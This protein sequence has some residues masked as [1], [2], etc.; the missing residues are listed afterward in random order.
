MPTK[1]PLE[2]ESDHSDNE[3]SDIEKNTTEQLSIDDI[4]ES[5]IDKTEKNIKKEKNIM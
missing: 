1:V 5:V 3:K 2:I 4:V